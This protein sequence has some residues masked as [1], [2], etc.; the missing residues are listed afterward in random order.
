VKCV[1]ENVKTIGLD[2][3]EIKHR[4]EDIDTS[5]KGISDEVKGIGQTI[6][7]RG[8]SSEDIFEF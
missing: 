1:N 8:V 4:G 2:V 6:Q 3:S 5:V 7:G